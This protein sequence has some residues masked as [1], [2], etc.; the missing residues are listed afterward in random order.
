MFWHPTNRGER[1]YKKGVSNGNYA[2]AR[3]H[4]EQTAPEQSK[5]LEAL[6]GQPGGRMNTRAA[7]AAERSC[8]AVATVELVY[9]AKK[10]RR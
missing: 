3:A 9:R 10:P 8:Q 1:G 7:Q 6:H 4:G 2:Q 5:V